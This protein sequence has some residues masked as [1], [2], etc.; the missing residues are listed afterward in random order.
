MSR[1]VLALSMG[2]PAGIGPE[3]ML[4]AAADAELAKLARLLIVGSETVLKKHASLLGMSFDA[5]DVEN[6]ETAGVGEIA[7]GKA[8]A[9]GGLASLA[10]VT[11][12]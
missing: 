5:A 12:A 1:P 3:L 6:V 9:A 4:K 11:R 10:Y 7:L 8:S 2:D